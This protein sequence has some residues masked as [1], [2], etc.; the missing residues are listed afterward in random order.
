MPAACPACRG[1]P[2]RFPPDCWRQTI[3]LAASRTPAKPCKIYLHC[4]FNHLRILRRRWH[5]T[6][7][8]VLNSSQELI[9]T[10]VAILDL[11]KSRAL[12]YKA[13]TVIRGAGLTGD[14]SLFVFLLFV[15]ASDRF[16]TTVNFYQTNYFADQLNLTNTNIDVHNSGGGVNITTVQNALNI[17]QP[18]GTPARGQ[19]RPWR[20]TR[21]P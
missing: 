21:N 15:P 18:S 2:N 1:Q 16:V 8:T 10:T 4:I 17:I 14:W 6:R 7:N 20:W 19:R 9:M 3:K 11:P 5:G 12:D 13:M